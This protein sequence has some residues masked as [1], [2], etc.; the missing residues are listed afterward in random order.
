MQGFTLLE[1]LLI[2]QG[3]TDILFMFNLFQVNL[4]SA[5]LDGLKKGYNAKQ[6]VQKIDDMGFM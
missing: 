3:A 4:I 6:G 2:Y 1:Y 5:Q